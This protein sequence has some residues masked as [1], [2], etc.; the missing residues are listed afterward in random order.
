MN[1]LK[2]MIVHQFASSLNVVLACEQ[3]ELPRASK[4]IMPILSKRMYHIGHLANSLRSKSNVTG[5]CVGRSMI[6]MLGVL[7]IIAVLTV[8]GIAG[9]SKAMEKWKVNKLLSEY[10]MIIFGSMTYLEQIQNLT[11]DGQ[12]D[13]K[14]DATAFLQSLDLFPQS[15]NIKNNTYDNDTPHIFIDSYGNWG[16]IYSRNHKYTFTLVLGGLTKSDEGYY[17]ANYSPLLCTQLTENL[18]KPL[19]SVLYDLLLWR[20]KAESYRLYGSNYC[21][22]QDRQCLS[23][24]PLTAIH[25]YCSNCNSEGS[26]SFTLEI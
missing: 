3:S 4:N 8:G 14:I 15:W 13:V 21:N 19:S 18:A 9:Y 24:T 5:N 22:G 6:E 20:S 10:S 7:A 2:K 1:K 12:G 16:R 25:Q 11:Y 26:C 23:Q 17:A